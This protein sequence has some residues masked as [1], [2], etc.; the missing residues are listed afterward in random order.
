[1]ILQFRGII[2][3]I[4]AERCW[5]MFYSTD[6]QNEHAQN[7]AEFL[8]KPD[9]TNSAEFRTK[10]NNSD[11][12]KIVT[13]HRKF[14]QLQDDSKWRTSSGSNGR[15]FCDLQAPSKIR[16]QKQRMR[17]QQELNAK[18]WSNQRQRHQQHDYEQKHTG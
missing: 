16:M 11:L 17:S 5:N 7:S 12:L 18:R 2:Q 14:S 6:F 1:M 15:N 9:T 4:Q 10:P 13:K 3:P 8:T